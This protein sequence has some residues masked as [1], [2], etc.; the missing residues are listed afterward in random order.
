MKSPDIFLFLLL[1]FLTPGNGGAQPESGRLSLPQLVSQAQGQSIAAR[2]AKTTMDTRYW[3]WRAFQSALRPQ[4][5]LLGNLP[6][7]TR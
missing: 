6:D 7:F 2:Q 3:E 5:L 1:I 4:L